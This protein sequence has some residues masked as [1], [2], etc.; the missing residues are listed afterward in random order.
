MFRISKQSL[1]LLAIGFA[2]LF[3][4]GGARHAIGLV[5]KPMAETFDWDRSVIGAAV[6]LFLF[7]SAVCMFFAGHLADRYSLKTILGG[8][9]FISALGIGLM[10]WI[11]EPWHAF[12]LYGGLFAMGNGIASITPVGVIMTRQFPDRAGL[13]NAA[14]ISG[15]GLG[16]L[17]IIAVLA[18]FL[19]EIGWRSVFFSVGVITILLLPFVLL[20][21]APEPAVAAKANGISFK[22]AL[23]MNPFWLLLAMYGICGFQDFFVS[24]HVVAFATDQGVVPVL[25]GNLLAFMGLAGLIGVLFAGTSSDKFGPIAATLACF[26][27]RTGIFVLIL[28]NKDAVSVSVFAILF[29]V[30]FWITAPLTVMFVRAHFGTRQLGAI[31]GFVTMIHHI[32]GGIGAFMGAKLFDLDGDYN[33]IFIVMGVSTV[34]AFILTLGLRQKQ[35]ETS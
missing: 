32:C 28:T 33:S 23:R 15:M 6:A 21:S 29:G 12:L 4:G 18:A 5:L 3:I 7:V 25:A 20:V 16:Q 14:V 30:T 22:K 24:T 2:V 13:A 8:G 11:S 10:G 19:V 1:V 35:I 27:V 26:V 17:I 31:T 34:L 9:V